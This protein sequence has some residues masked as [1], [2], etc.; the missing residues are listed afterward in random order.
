ML[1]LPPLGSI[2]MDNLPEDPVFYN[3][4]ESDNDRPHGH[5]IHMGGGHVLPDNIPLNP[6]PPPPFTGPRIG[7]AE[8]I[9]K[10]G[11]TKDSPDQTSESEE[12]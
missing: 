2:I 11:S 12:R 10:V 8:I 1:D 4:N 9:V 5:V 6:V 3:T 7:G